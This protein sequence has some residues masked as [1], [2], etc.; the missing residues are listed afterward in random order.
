MDDMEVLDEIE[1]KKKK[2][3][4]LKAVLNKKKLDEFELDELMGEAE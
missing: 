1:E 2:E 4:D 3:K